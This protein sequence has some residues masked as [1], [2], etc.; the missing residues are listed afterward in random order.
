MRYFEE[1]AQLAEIL[2]NDA[3]I[4]K[5]INVLKKARDEG[6]Q[7]F[8]AGNGGSAG[9]TSHFVCDL[10]KMGK[11]KAMS[12]VD[13]PSLMTALI[14]D[15]GWEEL[16]VQQIERFYCKGDI[17]ITISVHGG[18]GTDKAGKWSQN[19]MKAIEY[20]KNNN[21]ITI[22][23]TGFDGGA[24]KQVCDYCINIPAESTPLVESFHALVQHYIAFELYEG[25]RK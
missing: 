24:M 23:F 13:N 4:H 15:E 2:G 1:A 19:L 3:D 9:C 25:S 21:G 18:K 17:L 7:V 10:V 6:K 8:I 5:V 22:A 14:N 11:I 16:Y 20:V 12:L